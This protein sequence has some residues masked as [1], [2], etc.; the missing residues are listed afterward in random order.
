MI[1][2]LQLKRLRLHLYLRLQVRGV[3]L[4]VDCLFSKTNRT[5]DLFI[6]VS[7]RNVLSTSER[8]EGRV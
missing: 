3:R 7:A 1:E 6:R 8:S 2:F 4:H 5:I